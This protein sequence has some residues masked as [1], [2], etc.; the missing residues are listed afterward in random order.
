[1]IRDIFIILSTL[2]VLILPC[3]ADD[4]YPKNLKIRASLSDYSYDSS[5]EIEKVF[6][7]NLSCFDN[8]IYTII[9]MGVVVSINGYTFYDEGKDE[10]NQSAF[11]ILDIIAR[12]IKT[13]DKPCIVESNTTSTAFE[14]S[15]YLTNWELSVVR[16][17]NIV[18]YL[19]S[20]EVP[21]NQIRANGFGEMLPFFKD[22]SIKNMTE[23][24]DFIIFNYENKFK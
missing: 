21:S 20:K 11:C 18:S 15:N 24:I 1:M 2:L 17:N 22:S 16:S 4:I 19:I 7:E 8:I 9:P 3:Y 10:I 6:K 5:V 23:R 14:N 12:L 13:V